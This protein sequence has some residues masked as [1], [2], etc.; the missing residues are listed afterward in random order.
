MEIITTASDLKTACHE[1]AV[2]HHSEHFERPQV[3]LVPTLGSL[4]KGHMA[5]LERMVAECDVT[6]ASVFVNPTQFSTG[7]DYYEYPR[8]L[9]EDYEVCRKAGVQLIFAPE[10]DEMYP[11]GFQTTVQVGPLA[12]RWC[13]EA[14]PFHFHGV[15]TV[16]AKLIAMSGCDLAYFGEKDFQQLQ[17]VKRIATDL[18]MA[19]EIVAC[20][21]VREENGLAI[22][23]RN[24]YLADP[25]RVGAAKLY[26]GL[27]VMAAC[28]AGGVS[29]V[30][31]LV[32]EGRHAMVE[33]VSV[34][35]E[36]EYL[37]VVDPLTLEPRESAQLGDRILV[38]AKLGA[39]RLIDNIALSGKEQA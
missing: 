25:E 19:V 26:H 1:M 37:A 21:T 12:Q 15:T 18:N 35:P 9:D 28:F 33:H 30:E 34:K 13:G 17:I 27:K 23:S 39:T 11:E 6:I 38:A 20:P 4:H 24:S 10:P 7:E 22:S 32:L 31:S 8:T 16:V 2:A 5:L 3:G 14:R 36:I 29:D